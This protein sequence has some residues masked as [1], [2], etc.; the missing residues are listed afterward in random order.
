MIMFK[1]NGS[2]NLVGHAL[3]F[4]KEFPCHVPS[5]YQRQNKVED[6]VRKFRSKQ[7]EGEVQS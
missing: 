4:T 7:G 2:G 6:V 3:D 1:L 5:S